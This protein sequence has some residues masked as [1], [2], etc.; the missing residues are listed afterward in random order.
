MIVEQVQSFQIDQISDTR[1]KTCNRALEHK[2]E[3]ALYSKLT[4]LGWMSDAYQ[5]TE[6]Y[7]VLLE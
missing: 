5:G 1:W 3:V 4:G 6:S 2:L 7:M